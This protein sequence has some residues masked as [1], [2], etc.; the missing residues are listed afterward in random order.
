MYPTWV[1]Q[2]GTSLFTDVVSFGL[3]FKLCR[4]RMLNILSILGG[5]IRRV[6]RGGREEQCPNNVKAKL[7]EE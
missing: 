1:H 4:E 6:G 3:S 2:N 5:I 7:K